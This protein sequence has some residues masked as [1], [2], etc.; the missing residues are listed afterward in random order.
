MIRTPR[1][2]PDTGRPT[3]T[4]QHKRRTFVRITQVTV[5]MGRKMSKNFNSFDNSVGLTA[6]LTDDE[7]HEEVI[8]ALQKECFQ[9]LIKKNPF[10]ETACRAAQQQAAAMKEKKDGGR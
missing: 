4:H 1:V 2:E 7:N 6:N 8:V 5:Q 9:Q 3:T 10:D